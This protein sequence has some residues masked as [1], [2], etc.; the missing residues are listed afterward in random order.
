MRKSCHAPNNRVWYTKDS[1]EEQILA[2]SKR[3]RK[4][5][6]EAAQFQY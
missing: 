3:Q 4:S 6:H 2:S 1:V 5:S